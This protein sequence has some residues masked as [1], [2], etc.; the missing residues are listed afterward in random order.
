[1]AAQLGA[2]EDQQLVDD[3]ERV[4]GGEPGIP[5]DEGDLVGEAQAVIAPA[6]LL[7]L[8]QVL[9]GQGRLGD[10][11]ARA[12]TVRGPRDRPGE[13]SRKTNV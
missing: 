5:S 2:R 6:P 3:L 9:R 12:R 4:L 7:A 10:G 8:F 13:V 11:T 1:L